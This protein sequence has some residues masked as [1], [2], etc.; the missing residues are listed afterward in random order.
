MELTVPLESICHLIGRLQA[1]E[2]QVPG[3]DTDDDND[4]T[5]DGGD[6]YAMLE[7]DDDTAIEAEIEALLSALGDDE[8]AELLALAFVGC[9]LFDAG[10][11]DEALAAAN[12][13]DNA[14][15]IDQLLDMPMLAGYLDAGMAAFDLSCDDAGLAA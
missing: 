12:D 8:Q 11:W 7:A 9:G 10:E 3:L 2:A 15:R 5:T 14:S 13:T 6:P 1:F 4:D